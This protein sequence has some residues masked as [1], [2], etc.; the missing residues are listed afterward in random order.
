MTGD[1][2]TLNHELELMVLRAEPERLRGEIKRLRTALNAALAKLD[3]VEGNKPVP[4]YAE[5]A[6]FI[7]KECAAL[8]AA[9]TVDQL[10]YRDNALDLALADALEALAAT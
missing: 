9:Q 7:R 5:R 2:K 8:E 10:V 6:M 1:G 3:A 4:D